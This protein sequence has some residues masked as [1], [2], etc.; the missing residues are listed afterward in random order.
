[1]PSNLIYISRTVI[2]KYGI[3]SKKKSVFRSHLLG[4]IRS[5]KHWKLI[6]F[7]TGR[8]FGFTPTLLANPK[9]LAIFPFIRPFMQNILS[10]TLWT[11]VCVGGHKIIVNVGALF[12]LNSNWK[13]FRMRKPNFFV[14][15]GGNKHILYH[16]KTIKN[17]SMFSAYLRVQWTEW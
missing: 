7:W 13:H 2:N 3:A 16:P 15:K 5:N 6:F 17:K 4:S 1:M 11:C 12:I 14:G 10:L 9:I 8:E